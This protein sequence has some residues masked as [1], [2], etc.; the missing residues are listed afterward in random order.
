M[1]DPPDPK[2]RFVEATPGRDSDA[3]LLKAIDLTG[4]AE[5]SIWVRPR[6]SGHIQLTFDRHPPSRTSVTADLFDVASA[7]AQAQTDIGLV[8]VGQS[9]AEFT[10]D[11]KHAHRA[12]YV[13]LNYTA[14][15]RLRA[16][17]YRDWPPEG[18][19]VLFPM[20]PIRACRRAL[21][22]YDKGLV[23]IGLFRL[24][25]MRDLMR[26]YGQHGVPIQNLP[27]GAKV[28]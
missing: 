23:E 24:K 15:A 25:F 19:L 26:L 4:R 27:P 8:H 6:R 18:T 5:A 21:E 11:R 10:M 22:L 20:D 9:C 12:D 14:K 1:H 16:G 28:H 7:Y 13:E 17:G 3:R 2:V